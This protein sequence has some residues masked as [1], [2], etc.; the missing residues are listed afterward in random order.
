MASAYR[1]KIAN[2]HTVKYFNRIETTWKCTLCGYKRNTYQQHQVYGHVKTQRC[3]KSR[4]S[5]KDGA[6]RLDRNIKTR[7]SY[8]IPEI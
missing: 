6:Y 5:M 1:K 4:E 3:R 2:L 8:N 7:A